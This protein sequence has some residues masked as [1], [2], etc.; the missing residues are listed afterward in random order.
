MTPSP[1]QPH[2]QPPRRDVE[3]TV[4]HVPSSRRRRWKRIGMTSLAV[5]VLAVAWGSRGWTRLDPPVLV[6]GATTTRPPS[7]SAPT[8]TAAPT[9]TTTTVAPTTTA[10]VPEAPPQPEVF[11]IPVP[12]LPP[13]TTTTTTPARARRRASSTS[14]PAFIPVPDFL[15][16]RGAATTIPAGPTSPPPEAP[17]ATA[18]P[19][20]SPTTVVDAP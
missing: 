6:E 18:P 9:T 8:T 11:F 15:A 19:T 20:P 17:P 3:I 2:H 1:H 10:P 13:E 14:V 5:G 4:I 16:Q 12:E 7:T